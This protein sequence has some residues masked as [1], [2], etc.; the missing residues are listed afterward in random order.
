MSLQFFN[1]TLPHAPAKAPT[2]GCLAHVI[3]NLKD[4]S[5]FIA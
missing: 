1:L 4:V 2:D 3:S 5:L